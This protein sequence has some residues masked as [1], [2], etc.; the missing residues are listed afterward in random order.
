MHA[1][2]FKL[3]LIFNNPFIL[4]MYHD[5]FDFVLTIPHNIHTSNLITSYDESAENKG[6]DIA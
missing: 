5:G 6:C 4:V 1:Y 2:M 3:Y